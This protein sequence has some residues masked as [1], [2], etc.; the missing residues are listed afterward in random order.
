MSAFD[1]LEV[2]GFVR[3][4]SGAD[5]LSKLLSE[6]KLAFYAGFDAT[7]DSLHI[8]SLIPI[9]AMAHLQKAGHIPIALIGGGTTLIGDPSGKTEA[10]NL[11]S[12]EEVNVNG[13]LILEQL[14]RYLELEGEK[15]LFVNNANWLCP[16]NY[17]K[18]LRDIGQ[19]FKVNEMLRSE[20]YRARMEREDGLS[21]IEFNYMLL[22]AYDYL[23]LFDEHECLLQIGGDDQW[24]NILAGRDLIRRMR[25]S[26]VHALTFPLITTARGNKMGKTEKGAI[27]LDLCKTSAYEFYQ[28]WINTDDR[29]VGRFLLLFTF[30]D[31]EEIWELRN[32]KGSDLRQAKEV[33]AFEATKLAHGEEE[34]KRAQEQSQSIF[35]RREDAII[36]EL[37]AHIDG[38]RF[39]QG[40]TVVDVLFEAGLVKSKGE[41]RRLIQQRGAYV[42]DQKVEDIGATL[43]H[44][45]VKGGR[46]LLRRG[47][48]QYR[49]IVVT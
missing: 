32:L 19:H 21:F 1:V 40:L 20:A 6:C 42:N 47:K 29:D 37:T 13:A 27:W 22:Q 17:I 3:Q 11:M 31:V 43:T 18:F 38:Q 41:A 30:L 25:K 34:A 45:D 26:E 9:M 24:G 39:N 49:S 36:D 8:G 35:G 16:L 12:R 14:N 46:I 28:Y 4:S 5:E 7:A 33:L 2:R 15:G 10:R 48:K 44:E 23:V